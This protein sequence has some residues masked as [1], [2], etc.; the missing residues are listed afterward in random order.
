MKTSKSGRTVYKSDQTTKGNNGRKHTDYAKKEQEYQDAQN[1]FEQY[2]DKP[3]WDKMYMLINLA[4]FNSINK[5]LEHVLAREDIEGKAIDITNIIM[6][7]L[8][9]K[10]NAGKEWKIDKV[11]S[12][13]H[14]PCLAL[15][16][17]Q[18]HFEEIVLGESSYTGK[19]EFGEE[20]MIEF[21][22]SYNDGGIYHQHTDNGL[23]P[24][25]TERTIN[26]AI[27]ILANEYEEEEIYECID[28]LQNNNWKEIAT[29][30]QTKLIYRLGNLIKGD[31]D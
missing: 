19:D 12:Y 4:V 22:D 11:S 15:Y 6:S 25:K 10:K 14:L 5:K 24:E 13:V 27:V 29:D 3:S 17:K 8:L 30:K 31:E 2:N 7:G 1:H 28:M 23:A 26:E 18:L 16:R 9:K 20:T 21:E